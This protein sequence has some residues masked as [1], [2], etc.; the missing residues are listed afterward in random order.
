[1]SV[2]ANTYDYVMDMKYVW[3]CARLNHYGVMFGYA[4]LKSN[5]C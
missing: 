4:L 2:H 1:M 3:Y 5:V